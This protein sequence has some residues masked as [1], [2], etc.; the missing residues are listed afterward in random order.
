MTLPALSSVSRL[1][2]LI[3]LLATLALSG[4]GYTFTNNQPSLFGD[5]SS[6]M[7]IREVKN[8]TI[9]PWI[10]QVV[11]TAM[12]DEITDRNLAV[13]TASDKAD[14]S[15]VIDVEKFT[16][17]SRI[18]GTK[19]ETLE[20]TV[21]II[22]ST[23]VYSKANKLVWTSDKTTLSRSYPV[24]DERTAGVEII[25]LLVEKMADKMRNTF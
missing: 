6:T 7:R 13:M 22:F 23:S 24:S 2:A 12:Y 17:N 1:C 25:N 14:Y 19:D 20:Y 8:S 15:M 18:K 5:G 16:I 11:R 9:Y 3:C 4:C 21:T 10:T